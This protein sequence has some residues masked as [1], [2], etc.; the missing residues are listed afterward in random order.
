MSDSSEGDPE[1]GDGSGGVA[2]VVAE[3]SGELDR[4]GAAEHTDRQIA[5]EGDIADVVQA[6][7]DR[8][9]APEVVSQPGGAGLREVRLVIA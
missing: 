9:V 2:S 5:G 6:V 8:P 4:P 3:G 1:A 7:P